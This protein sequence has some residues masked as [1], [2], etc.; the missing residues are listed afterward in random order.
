MLPLNE[1]ATAFRS[2][3]RRISALAATLVAL[4]LLTSCSEDDGLGKRFPVSGTVTYNGK[5]LEQ[6]T[7]SFVS[8][9][10]RTNY[11]A[12]GPIKEGYFTLSTGGNDDG[13][14]A[15]K[16]KVTI[17]AKEDSYA[18]AKANFEKE[19]GRADAGFIPQQFIHKA[20]AEAKSLIPPGYGDPRT[21]T[22]TAEVKTQSNT[23]EFK[24][25]DAD[26]PPEPAKIK[27]AKGGRRKD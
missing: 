18:K 21:T 8:E 25:S 19:S 23:I 2:P 15:G 22:L 27:G 17:T 3:S 24:L 20:E 13:A 26:A 16:Y 5:P 9:D 7:I 11:G 10:L 6:G 12:S 14:Q 4:G 1:F